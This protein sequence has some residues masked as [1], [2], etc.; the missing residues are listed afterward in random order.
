MSS[1]NKLPLLVSLLLLAGFLALLFKTGWLCEDAFITLTPIENLVHGYG[2]ASNIG[3]RVQVYTHP[4]WY[5]LQSAVYFVSLRGLNIDYPSQLFVNSISLNILFSLAAF[6]LM[7]FKIA[8]DKRSAL[9]AGLLLL[10]SKAFVEYSTSGLENPLGHLI[11][12]AFLY[13]SFVKNENKNFTPRQYFIAV[14]IAGLGVL[15]RYDTVLFYFPPLLYFW[16]KS[17]QKRKLVL[18]AIWALLPLFLYLLFSIVYFGFALPNTFYAKLHSGFSYRALFKKG[19]QYLFATFR[20]DPLS[21]A[22]LAGA[23]LLVIVRKKRDF[24]PLVIGILL[25]IL[26]IFRVGG[27]YMIGRFVSLAVFAAVGIIA[28]SEFRPRPFYGML[29]LALV[30]GLSLRSSPVTSPLYYNRDYPYGSPILPG[31]VND[32]RARFQGLLEGLL[33]GFPS[34]RYSGMQWVYTESIPHEVAVAG[35]AGNNRYKLGPNVYLIDYNAITD[36]LLARLPVNRHED[37]WKPG[38]LS[39][40]VPAGY[41][42]SIQWDDNRI[43]NE[44]LHA[45]YDALLTVIHGSIFSMERFR[46]IYRL[47][48]G[49]YD[50]LLQDYAKTLPPPGSSQ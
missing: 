1:K 38:H 50:T 39:R 22:I 42:E 20:L 18:P 14:F 34:N 33:T 43:E 31:R 32:N 35:S 13:H 11:M 17:E 46:E 2:I 12:A 25:Y 7:M 48:T 21:L 49:Y 37:H 27:D 10:L 19:W 23:F 36:P 8:R 47:N 6:A 45:Y 9:L 29:A 41:V 3:Y 30:L 28:H 4:L 5:L 16:L 24:Y 44:D 26:Y 40:I 15:N